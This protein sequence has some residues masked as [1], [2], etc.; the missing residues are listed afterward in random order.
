MEEI[1]RRSGHAR[2]DFLLQLLHLLQWKKNDFPSNEPLNFELFFTLFAS[3]S[4]SVDS[5]W[6]QCSFQ[7]ESAV[8]KSPA[9]GSFQNES[10]YEQKKERKLLNMIEWTFKGEQNFN[11]HKNE[12]LFFCF[13]PYVHGGCLWWVLLHHFLSVM[14]EGRGRREIALRQFSKAHFSFELVCMNGERAGDFYAI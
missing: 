12:T 6:I 9:L 7:C 11:F 14:G 13:Y 8:T 3:S 1:K 4:S 2:K 10:E 5:N